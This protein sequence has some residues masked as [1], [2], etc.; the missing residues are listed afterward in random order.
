LIER[1]DVIVEQFRPG[2]MARFDLDYAAV[3]TI[4]PR[5]IYCS[6]TAYG[7]SGSKRDIPGHDLNLL[8]DTGLLALSMGD[9]ADAALPPTPIADIGAGAYP[10]V[11]NIMLA[12][13]ERANTGRGRYIDVSLS[14][15]LFTF[16]YWALASGWATGQWPGNRT[17]LV[18]GGTARYQIYATR[19]GKAIAAA[20]LEQKF[21][22][23]FCAVVGLSEDLRDDRVN[24]AATLNAVR[25]I[26]AA[27]D[28]QSWSRRF[29]E[30]ECCCTVVRSLNAAQQDPHFVSRGLFD[31][32]L[33]NSLG[34]T[35]PALPVPI[36]PAFRAP[37]GTRLSAP[38]LERTVGVPR[39]ARTS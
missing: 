20:P 31:H 27:D 32:V 5:V 16:A 35:L 36:D 22:D 29:G 10:A 15:N 12:L 28:A 23:N 26:I 33:F 2:V 6:I 8:A 34:A 3:A 13:Q 4:N 30:R 37:Q 14:D 7:Q 19:D 18:T 11:L 25:R 24:P 17:D 1:A 38:R 9:P 21:W 39:A